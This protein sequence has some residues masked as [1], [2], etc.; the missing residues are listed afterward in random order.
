ML[1]Y[2]DLFI[3]LVSTVMTCSPKDPPM[4]TDNHFSSSCT[5]TQPPTH[6]GTTF[7]TAV[8]VC[9]RRNHINHKDFIPCVCLFPVMSGN[10]ALFSWENII[11]YHLTLNIGLE[12]IF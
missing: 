8:R 11:S 7:P 3:Y 2:L 1:T 9:I 6:V 4:E 5:E 12:A 10:E